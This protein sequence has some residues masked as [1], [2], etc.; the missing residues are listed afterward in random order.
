MSIQSG[1]VYRFEKS[2]NLVK[3]LTPADPYLGQPMWVV[4]RVEGQSAGKQLQVPAR[5]LARPDA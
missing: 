1:K 4:E 2:G 3:A 5:A